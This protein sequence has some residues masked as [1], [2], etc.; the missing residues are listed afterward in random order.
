MDEKTLEKLRKNPHYKISAKNMRN[1]KLTSTRKEPMV[2]FGRPEL[3]N[4]DRPIHPTGP[5]RPDEKIS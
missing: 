1:I 2:A 3:H 4:T 5:T